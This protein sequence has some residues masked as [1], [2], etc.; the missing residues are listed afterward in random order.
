MAEFPPLTAGRH[1]P[2]LVERVAELLAPALSAPGA[3]IVD[4]TVGLGGHAAVLLSR[5]PD[6]RLL[7]ID[8]DPAALKRAG[9]RLAGFGPRVELV[10]AVYDRLPELLAERRLDHV[11]A[12]LFDLGV[13]SLQLD[14]DD[15]GFAYSRDTAL[16]MRMDPTSGLTAAD[17]LA[18]Y[19]ADR[20]SRIFREYGEERFARRIARAIVAERAQRPVRS[21]A[22]LADLIRDAI[23]AP[24]RRTGGNPAKRVFQALR[25][26]VNGELDALAAAIPAAIDALAS[27]GRIV[28]LAYQ[29]LEDRLIKRQ[30]ASR[31]RQA[32]PPDLPIREEKTDVQLELLTRGA[33]KASGTEIE[34]NPRSRPVRLRAAVRTPAS[35]AGASQ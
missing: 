18:S 7:G 6:L 31:S 11:G 34:F 29:S 20:L 3:V 26:E 9:S 16:D 19:D 21:T 25:I 5:H 23:P 17:V 32:L 28:T 33:E 1:E 15:R 35:R 10:H 27:G 24:A 22:Q 4:A 2:V 14:S 8:R 30:F 13:S 12:V